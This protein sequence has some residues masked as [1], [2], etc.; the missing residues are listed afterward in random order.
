[1]DLCHSGKS[2]PLIDIALPHFRYGSW[3]DFFVAVSGDC[4]EYPAPARFRRTNPRPRAKPQHSGPPGQTGQPRHAA[5]LGPGDRAC[6]V[7]PVCLGCPVFRGK[8]SPL[9]TSSTFSTPLCASASLRKNSQPSPPHSAPLRLCV[10]ALKL[11]TFATPSLAIGNIGIGNIITLAT[12]PTVSV[13]REC[14]LP[15]IPW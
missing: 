4:A 7:R 6:P 13:P 10:S 1:M 12:F 5:A 2:A 3:R 11:S 9:S 8:N 15:R 14:A